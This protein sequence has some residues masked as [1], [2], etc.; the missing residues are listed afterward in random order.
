M[1]HELP[2]D[3]LSQLEELRRFRDLYGSNYNFNNLAIGGGG[4]MA[5]TSGV[6]GSNKA[7]GVN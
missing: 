7:G 6:T 1:N 4:S 5:I 3:I 2:A